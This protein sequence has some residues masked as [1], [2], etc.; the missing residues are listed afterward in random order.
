MLLGNR[1]AALRHLF[2][3]TQEDVAK[4]LDISRSSYSHY[5]VG[6]S[7]PDIEILKKLAILFNVSSDYLLGLNDGIKQ[8]KEIKASAYSEKY[9]RNLL[10]VPILNTVPFKNTI[11]NAEH[12]DKYF[13]IDNSAINLSLDENIFFLRLVGNSMEPLFKEGD[14]ILIR[15]QKHVDNGQWAAVKLPDKDEVLIKKIYEFNNEVLLISPNPNQEPVKFGITSLKI[16]GA[17]VLRIGFL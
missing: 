13:C 15:Q 12:I 17:A 10:R 6:R 11:F 3:L 9:H 7:E 1:L 4:K 16:I 14:L 5:E 8:S 2:G